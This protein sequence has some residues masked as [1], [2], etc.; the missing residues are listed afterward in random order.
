MFHK[1]ERDGTGPKSFDIAKEAQIPEL[2]KGTK[3]NK[4]KNHRP[5]SF[6]SS[7]QNTT[8][9]KN[10]SQIKVLNKATQHNQVNFISGIQYWF[11][12]CK[13]INLL[14][15]RTGIRR[16]SQQMQKRHLMMLN[17]NR[18]PEETRNR[19]NMIKTL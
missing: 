2:D 14:S 1:I 7:Q 8:T 17:I 12:I 10:K 19:R 5:I 16:S 6:K 3:L 9:K 15:L 11:D 4:T 18:G 13:S